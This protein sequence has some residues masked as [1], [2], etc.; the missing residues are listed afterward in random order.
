VR[1]KRAKEFDI[2][3]PTTKIRTDVLALL[4]FARPDR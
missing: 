2:L 3:I 4:L 1:G